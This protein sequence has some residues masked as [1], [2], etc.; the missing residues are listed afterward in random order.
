MYPTFRH[1]RRRE[2]EPPPINSLR[3]RKRGAETSVALLK[4]QT[5]V[6]GGRIQNTKT[7]IRTGIPFLNRMPVLGY[8]FGSTEE[9]IEKTELLM[10]ITPRVVGTALDAARA[11]SQMR[12][13]TPELA[14]CFKLLPKLPPPTQGPDRLNASKF[15][16]LTRQCRGCYPSI[17]A[18]ICLKICRF[19][20]ERHGWPGKCSPPSVCW[21][22]ASVRP[23][24]PQAR[25]AP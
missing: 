7:W 9:K 8:L 12:N 6:L 10:L 21:P 19:P 5:L 18:F 11:T 23:A 2:N 22:S 13:V 20:P 24:R 16:Q 4:N 1:R 15:C 3:F 25:R 14:Q 17:Q